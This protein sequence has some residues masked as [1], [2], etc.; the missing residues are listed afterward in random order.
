MRKKIILALG[1]AATVAGALPSA[2]LAHD[3]GYHRGWYKHD[4]YYD[5]GPRY[6][7]EA[8]YD[9]RG[10]RGGCRTSGTT[11]AII[12][13]GAG[14]LLGRS[15]DRHGDRLPG[16]IIGAGAGALIGKEIDSKHRC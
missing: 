2:A 9:R 3:N 1:F 15:V 7:R 16:T 10:Y 13:A 6:R 11:G 14:A 12:G 5:D 8:Y 4:R